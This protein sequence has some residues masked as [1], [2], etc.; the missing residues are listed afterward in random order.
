[1]EIRMFQVDAFA[2]EL[3]GGNPAAVCILEEWL[4]DNIMLSIAGE[5][6]LAETAFCI[7][8]GDHVELKWFTPEVEID[9]CGHATLATS[10]VLMHELGDFT[11]E[12]RY[13]TRSGDLVVTRD[14]DLYCLDFP[15]R[16]PA[17][18]HIPRVIRE[19]IGGESLE[20]LKARDYFFVFNSESEVRN[21]VPDQRLLASIEDAFAGI[22]I[23]A[24]GDTTDFVSRFFTP[25]ASVFE[26]PVTGSAHCTLIPYW[27]AKLQKKV[28][29]A[30]QLSSRGGE[31]LCENR[32]Q[33]VYIRG[34]AVT[35]M[36]G[37]ISI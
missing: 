26:D 36:R 32:G 22:I 2:D 33:R 25:G 15:S 34:K 8:R 24:P 9:L 5:N 16:P 4:P 10:H 21:I 3:F 35:F 18:A 27:S 17:A 23:T 30:K 37:F 7:L 12:V 20:I 1:M 29:K 31:L 6:N 28:L 13:L 11:D 19:G 14:K